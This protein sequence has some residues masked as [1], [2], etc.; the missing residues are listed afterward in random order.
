MNDAPARPAA[1]LDESSYTVSIEEAADRYASAGLPRP[2]RRLQ[3]YC[4]RGDLECRKVE[5]PSG[6]KYLITPESIERHIAYVE[7]TSGRALAR[8]AASG[9]T[10]GKSQDSAER[11][12]ASDHAQPR[13]GAPSPD[14]LAIFEHPYV[15]RLER[16]VDEYKGKYE[17]QVKRTEQVL[18]DA[19][20]RLIELQQA[21]AIGS[22]EIL[23]KYMLQAKGAAA[24]ERTSGQTE[25]A[26]ASRA[27]NSQAV[28]TE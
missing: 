21:N 25:N 28:P 7:E 9:R 5:T 8:P 14:A 13:L 22:S 20:V 6:E 23:A 24:G 17:R 12:D 3:K 15:K 11:R 1:P 27:D 16:E 26:S 19:N 4:A 18:E 10:S 2:I